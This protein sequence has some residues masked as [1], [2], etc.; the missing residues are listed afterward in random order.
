[1]RQ[2]RIYLP[3]DPAA[4]R[5]LQETRTLQA[6]EAYAVTQWLERQYPS[7][8]EEGLEFIALGEAKQAALDR[9]QDDRLVI[10]AA[11][12]ESEHLDMFQPAVGLPASSVVLREPVPLRRI[13]SFHLEETPFGSRNDPD[14]LWYDVTELDEVVRQLS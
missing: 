2:C 5:T 13:V 7:E 8:D 1:M 10:V 14:L 3:I 6:R 9:D 4:V 12:V 11:D